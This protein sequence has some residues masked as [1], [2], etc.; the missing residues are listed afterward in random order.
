MPP[1]RVE[2]TP[3]AAR[4]LRRVRTHELLALRGVILAL[5]SDLRPAGAR[6]LSGGP[7]LWRLRIRID[8]I[9]WRIIFGVRRRDRLI[10]VAR[11]VR[12]DEG[13]YRQ[14]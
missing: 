3:G 12:R 6:K 5:A 1:R 11:V 10:V 9:G 4:E 2:L 8:G 7:D 13:T 14:L